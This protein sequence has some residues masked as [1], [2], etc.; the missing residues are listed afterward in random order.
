MYL[1]ISYEPIRSPGGEITGIGMATVD[2]TDK[3]LVEEALQESEERFRLAL[4]NAPVFCR[5][6]GYG[7]CFPMGVQPEN[8]RT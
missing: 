4:R 2:L 5:D 3:K 8:D 6:P 1:D 7:S